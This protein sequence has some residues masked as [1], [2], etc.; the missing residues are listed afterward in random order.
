M[1]QDNLF[2]RRS[3]IKSGALGLT[4]LTLGMPG[5][6]AHAG[7]HDTVRVGV[8]GVG[9]RGGGISNIIRHLPGIE[10][11]ACADILE[12]RLAQATR[13]ASGRI[14]AYQDYRRLLED[15]DVDAVIVAVPG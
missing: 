4:G 2:T 10:V 6:I 13:N 11:V 9:S 3:F 8:I 1:H 14:R 12:S 15:R 5:L 7:S